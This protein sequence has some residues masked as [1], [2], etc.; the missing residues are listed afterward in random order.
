MTI[1]VHD[2]ATLV[3]DCVP[4]TSGGLDIHHQTVSFAASGDE[5]FDKLDRFEAAK[6]FVPDVM[7]GAQSH[8]AHVWLLEGGKLGTKWARTSN[9]AGS[10]WPAVAEFESDVLVVCVPSDVAVPSSPSPA[11]P[12]APGTTQRKVRVK[13][14]R[15]GGL[16]G[17]DGE[18]P[19][20][21]P[22]H[23]EASDTLADPDLDLL[24]A[25]R[26]GDRRAAKALLARHYKTI[27]AAVLT[28]IPDA[29][30]DDV[31][32]RVV[33]ALL[34]GRER[35]RGDAT[36]RT[37]AM[38]VTRRVI[39]NYYRTRRSTVPLDALEQSAHANGVGMSTLLG[40]Q[41]QQRLL[42]EA[43][44]SI[45]LD[46]QFLLELHYWEAM[47]GPALAQVFE[48]PEPTIRGRLRR[49]KQR[50]R[51]EVE[52]IAE[53]R[54]ELADTLTDLDAWAQR[55]REALEVEVQRKGPG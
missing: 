52:K 11:G 19:L 43:L 45:T 1:N 38:T 23:V 24:A 47:S 49:A 30:V 27:R 39:G 29:D 34:E 53:E 20:W 7:V 18:P 13:V 10:S 37:Y 50:L 25:W 16:P 54:R 31:V 5:I 32:S 6:V 14:Q 21:P 28:K 8:G 17:G 4:Q 3:L 40:D 9:P 55:L 2:I 15:Q 35:F 51:V 46:D 48:C 22:N 42:L 44:R 36:F 26:G 41:Q 33:V 12:P